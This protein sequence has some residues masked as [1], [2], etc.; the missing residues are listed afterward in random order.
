M[1]WTS[2]KFPTSSLQMS[3][4]R[5][6]ASPPN[7]MPANDNRPAR[8]HP[9]RP[10]VCRWSLAEDGTGLT[11]HWEAETDAE[12]VIPG[13]T[14]QIQRDFMVLHVCHLSLPSHGRFDRTAFQ[15]RMICNNH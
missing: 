2:A 9:R 5:N 6:R 8:M 14:I 11:C 13:M 1:F 15:L 4:A 10:L 12:D 3:P 7:R